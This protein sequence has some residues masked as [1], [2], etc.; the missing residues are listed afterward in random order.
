MV[1]VVVV[2]SPI[3]TFFQM[4][5]LNN[6][7]LHQSD[8]KSGQKVL[9]QIR[10]EVTYVGPQAVKWVQFVKKVFR[11]RRKSLLANILD[12]TSTTKG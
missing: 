9:I 3:N 8:K 4:I 1:V 10:L 5:K 11:R 6:Q 2:V 12:T 7:A